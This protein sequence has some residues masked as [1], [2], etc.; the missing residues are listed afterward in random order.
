MKTEFLKQKEEIKVRLFL[1]DLDDATFSTVR[2]SILQMD[3]IPSIKKVYAMITTEEQHKQVSRFSKN[4]GGIAFATVKFGAAKF[5]SFHC[6]KNYHDVS[7]CF[8][9]I[10]YLSGCLRRPSIPLEHCRVVAV[11]GRIAAVVE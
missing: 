6:Y 2:S 7:T 10:G 3:P 9:H 8:Q 1:L 5:E 4:E 11:R